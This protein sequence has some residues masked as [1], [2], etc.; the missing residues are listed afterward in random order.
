MKRLLIFPLLLIPLSVSLGQLSIELRPTKHLREECHIAT[1][2]VK[3][4][5][6][7]F[8]TPTFYFGGRKDLGRKLR[9][10]ELSFV[11]GMYYRNIIQDRNNHYGFRFGW[12]NSV[13]LFRN[14][15]LMINLDW[16]FIT[17]EVTVAQDGL[18]GGVNLAVF[19]LHYWPQGP[20]FSFI[21]PRIVIVFR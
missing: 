8:F 3:Y 18:G 19:G 6:Y 2:F 10:G 4:G 20:A 9:Y 21:F 5:N 14:P 7:E 17:G 13:K 1:D 15:E 12:C 11:G 16:N